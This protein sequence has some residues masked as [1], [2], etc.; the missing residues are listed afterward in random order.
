M[1]QSIDV[2][3]NAPSLPIAH[4]KRPLPLAFLILTII[5]LFLCARAGKDLDSSGWRDMRAYQGG[6]VT[7]PFAAEQVDLV[8]HEATRRLRL[9]DDGRLAV[10]PF[11]VADSAM[12]HAISRD[13]REGAVDLNVSIIDRS[14][15][16]VAG[17]LGVAIF[18]LLFW[19]FDLKVAAALS[20]ATGGMSL[21]RVQLFLWFLP[22][23]FMVAALG[24]PLLALPPIDKSLAEL[25]GLSGL[26]TMLGAATSPPSTSPDAPSGPP[27]KPMIRDILEDWQSSLDFSRVQL[28]VMTLL[29]AFV[30]FAAF[31]SSL[32]IPSIPDGW[33][34]VL[35][36]SQVAYV[37]TKAIKES[38]KNLAS[39]RKA[40][41]GAHG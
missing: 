28:I 34:A 25:F 3:G 41:G 24:I 20:E 38:K 19:S 39:E 21:A 37:G 22:T 10:L 32:R 18:L 1:T 29:G 5:T 2:S 31:V 9:T 27:E 7:L 16:L 17:V 30:L 6:T 33:L 36:A 26:T 40:E 4:P 14:Y 35:G 8:D 13:K 23:L 15:A 12:L 11:D